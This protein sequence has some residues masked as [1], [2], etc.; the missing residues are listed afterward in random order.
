MS[1]SDLKADILDRAYDDIETI[2]SGFEAII[3]LII[4]LFAL[5]TFTFLT[6]SKNYID[7]YSKVTKVKNNSLISF[8]V[9][10]RNDEKLI[11]DL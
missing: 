2:T 7:P 11:V 5:I 3:L 9:S 1:L 6:I 4:G 10:V 8:F